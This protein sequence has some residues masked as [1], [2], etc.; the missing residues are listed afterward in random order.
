MNWLSIL[1]APRY[2]GDCRKKI[3]QNAP[4]VHSPSRRVSRRRASSVTADATPKADEKTSR[5]VYLLTEIALPLLG[6]LLLFPVPPA[7]AASPRLCEVHSVSDGDTLKVECG[8]RKLQ[9]RMQCID[10]PE[11]SQEPWGR[12][13]RDQLRRLMPKR[14]R[15][16]GSQR[17]NYGRLVAE[18]KDPAN[19]RNLNLEMVRRGKAA[20]YVNYCDQVE[21]FKAQER[22]RQ[23]GIGIW[24]RPG[25]QQKPWQWRREHR[26]EES[27]SLS[28]FF[29]W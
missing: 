7:T 3:Y 20:V 12:E 22:A 24:E 25:M 15:I 23:V 9:I 26:Q 21:Y 19:K 28:S 5:L 17:D 2:L 11:L 16:E 13:A 10:A 8:R 1:P 29:R 4:D 6:L 18:V 27:W 14:V